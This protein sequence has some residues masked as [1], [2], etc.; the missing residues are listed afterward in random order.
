MGPNCVTQ[1]GPDWDAQVGPN[2]AA[3]VHNMDEEPT[4]LRNLGEDGVYSKFLGAEFDVNKEASTLL[5]SAALSEQLGHIIKGIALLDGEIAD[6][7]SAHYEDLLSQATGTETLD[8]V[9]QSML[10]RIQALL[11][12]VERLRSRVEEPFLKIESQSLMLSRLHAACDMLRRLI[13]LQ[14]LSKRLQAQLKGG[15]RDITKAAKS[16]SE[17]DE[18]VSDVDLS[19]LEVFEREQRQIRAGR[20]LVEKQAAGLLQRGMEALNQSQVATA[21]QVCH[22]LGTLQPTVDG[23]LASTR[24]Q[25][26]TRLTEALQLEALVS[27]SSA[28]TPGQGRPGAAALP[29]S[30]V[31]FRAA[32]WNN[33]ER[34]AD[35]I[36][37]A[38]AQIQHIHKVLSKKR[39]PVTQVCFIDEVRSGHL[40]PIFWE[41]VTAVIRE[42]FI[43]A[44]EEQTFIKQAFEGEYP[45]LVRLNYDLWT[46]L[47]QFA[48]PPA[49]DG[50]PQFNPEASLREALAPFERAYLSRSVSRL[51]DPVNLMF[52]AETVP[53]RE[54]VDA[55]VR[56]IANEL[57]VSGVDPSLCQLVARN[58]AKTVHLFCVKC[59]QLLVT[60]GDAS[61]VIGPMSPGQTTNASLVNLLHAFH[62]QLSR[63]LANQPGLAAEA[64]ATVQAALE[65]VTALMAAGIQPLLS[66]IGEAIEAIILTMHNED[67][68][69]E[70]DGTSEASCSLYM[71]E[72]QAF[73]ARVVDD[74][75]SPFNCKQLLSDSKLELGRRA[76]HLFVRHAALVRPMGA[77]GR[78]KMAADCAQAELAV[79]PLVERLADLGTAYRV[80]RAYRPLLF[81]TSEHVAQSPALGEVLPY[82]LVLHML[83]A[84][85]PAELR[86]PHHTASWSVSRYSA[87]LDEHRSERERLQLLAGA[88]DAHVQA[89]RAQG[90]T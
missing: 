29:S 59:E 49:T 35:H 66:S 64:R 1:A 12:A 11:A 86:S 83:F 3:Q 60:D 81:Q 36:Y 78:L 9:L 22:S 67:F 18:T 21:L 42:E 69:G 34:L 7:V 74:Y 6:Q 55:V 4:I 32:L 89:V 27:A 56:T 14:Y 80:L 85:G 72:L 33:L 20:Q 77:A 45:K 5:Q 30:T 57:N 41:D 16:L 70:E 88:L 53:A 13:R 15:V 28:Q 52:S 54:E 58:V 25:L 68:S 26:K 90:G 63:L 31:T 65:S 24:A 75:L 47:Q 37:G 38:C 84:R 50:Q 79:T 17:L 23:L 73:I 44:A 61:Q 40:M 10:T 87:W 43:R 39:D 82:S 71:K 19:G 51:F 48:T 62:G 46:R 76:L 2:W 8:D